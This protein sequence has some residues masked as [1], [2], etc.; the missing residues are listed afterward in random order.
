MSVDRM[1]KQSP[2]L[3]LDGVSKHFAGIAALTGV[4]FSLDLGEIVALVGDN[5]AGKSTLVK[6]ISGIH[7]PD[8]GTIRINGEP[9]HLASPSAASQRGIQ[10]VYQDLALCENLDTI[11]NLFLGRERCDRWFRAGRLDRAGM[12]RR[13][14]EVLASLDVRLRDLAAPISAL[15]GGQRQSV[16][17]CRSILADPRV[18]LLD[19]PTA[20]LGV[21]Q[22]RQVLAL[23][24]RLKAQGR[25]VIVISHDLGDVQHIADRVVVLRLGRKVAELAS[26]IEAGAFLHLDKR[27]TAPDIQVAFTSIFP[28]QARLWAPGLGRAPIHSYGACLWPS[29]PSSRGAITLRSPD[30]QAAPAIDPN[31]L[32]DERDLA[33]TRA[34][35]REV[36]RVLSQPAFA[37]IR[38]PEIAPGA[39]VGSD[40]DL[41][42]FIRATGA[43]G[44]HACGSLKMG[45]DEMAVVDDRLRVHGLDGL[46][47]A[48]ASIMPIMVSGNTNATT[49]M[50]GEKASDLVLGRSLPAEDPK[51][52]PAPEQK[53]ARPAVASRARDRSPSRRS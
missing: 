50:I 27:E 48:D 2:I 4:S 17:V 24:E 53:E 7:Q 30:P 40:A 42:A 16:A 6:T 37:A 29:R 18:V 15:S 43:S 21:A 11:Q 41:D 33:I 8:E 51:A 25:G 14:R 52:A 34:G 12:E 26:P 28:E 13:T 5:G 39:A 32:A 23:I 44:H 38:G 10:T 46:R 47:V 19:E 31:F 9:V 36:R 20:A 35:I 22:R 1:T 45:P 49:I 3:E